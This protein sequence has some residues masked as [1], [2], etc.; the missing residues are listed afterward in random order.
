MLHTNDDT[1]ITVVRKDDYVAGNYTRDEVLKCANV[2][3]GLDTGT[4][5]DDPDWWRE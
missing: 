4:L 1:M 3:L 5:D 2:S